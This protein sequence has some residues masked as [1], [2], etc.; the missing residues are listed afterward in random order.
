MCPRGTVNQEIRAKLQERRESTFGHCLACQGNRCELKGWPAD[1]NSQKLAQLCMTFFCTPI[2]IPRS[3]FV[4]ETRD[5]Q[6]AMQFTYEIN[7]KGKADNFRITTVSGDLTA[8]RA[9]EW[10]ESLFKRRKFLPVKIGDEH[11]VITN[12]RSS[13]RIRS[14]LEVR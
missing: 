5:M 11:Y 12:L 3:T 2:K 4:P 14:N 6:G 10:A 1:E 9:L 13:S 7:E 8:T